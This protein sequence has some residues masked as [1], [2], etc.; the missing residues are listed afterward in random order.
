MK[1]FIIIFIFTNLLYSCTNKI[2][3]GFKWVDLQGL[4]FKDSLVD[5]GQNIA[6]VPVFNDCI[7]KYNGKEIS[8][9]G[10]VEE[11]GDVGGGVFVLRKLGSEGAGYGLAWKSEEMIELINFDVDYLSSKIG[12]KVELKGGFHLNAL[13]FNRLLFTLYGKEI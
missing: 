4:N 10:I 9:N 7:T 5:S 12:Q 2:N 3:T 6:S 13:D 11:L 1:Y 8:V